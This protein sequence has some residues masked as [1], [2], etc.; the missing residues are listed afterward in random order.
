MPSTD[1]EKLYMF[2]ENLPPQK[3]REMTQQT[4][5]VEEVMGLFLAVERQ[6][7]SVEAKE[8]AGAGIAALICRT[9]V[10]KMGVDR[11]KLMSEVSAKSFPED[12]DGM[13]FKAQA[14]A[15]LREEGD[16]NA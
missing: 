3:Q 10:E 11:R 5:T 6:Y 13:E 1:L 12:E 14:G 4:W 15:G 7:S 9:L 16:E 2:V 8:M